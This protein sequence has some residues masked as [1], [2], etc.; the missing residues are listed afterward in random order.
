MSKLRERR[1][2]KDKS[3]SDK[4]KSNKT[5][6]NKTTGD[7]TKRNKIKNRKQKDKNLTLS[8]YVSKFVNFY[9]KNTVVE[10]QDNL[11]HNI[12]QFEYDRIYTTDYV[13]KV[14]YIRQAPKFV[15]PGYIGRI[16]V[17]M[18]A[19]FPTCKTNIIMHTEP[20]VV[21]FMEKKL[22]DKFGH[23]VTT[24][25]ALEKH[26]SELD[27]HGRLKENYR[28]RT[29]DDR[30]S[31]LGGNTAYNDM[32][33][34]NIRDMIASFKKQE[35]NYKN[36]GSSM[37][38]AIFVECLAPDDETMNEYQKELELELETQGYKIRP[39]QEDLKAY[40]SYYGIGTLD[41]TLEKETRYP[42]SVV[43]TARDKAD[44]LLYS[45][46]KIGDCQIYCGIDINEGEAVF[47]NFTS[48]SKA[49][50]IMIVAKSGYGKTY[51][52]LT[53][54][55][56]HRIQGHRI[57]AMD[58][59]GNEW[60][61]F[62]DLYG[63]KIISL[64]TANPYFM[65]TLKISLLGSHKDM[66]IAYLNAITATVKLINILVNATP[67]EDD[68]VDALSNEIIE[69]VYSYH[70]I[71]KDNPSTYKR[72][73]NIDLA[74]D[75][76]RTINKF[77]TLDTLQTKFGDGILNLVYRRLE[78]YFSPFGA[79]RYL[80]SQEV[81]ID[82]IKQADSLIF[83]LGM[84]KGEENT[85]PDKEVLLKMHNMQ[86]I[87]DLYTQYNKEQGIFT[88]KYFEEVQRTLNNPKFM[89]MYNTVVT[90]ERSELVIV[91]LLM[92]TVESL[93]G[94]DNP[95]ALAIKENITTKL[96]GFLEK[97]P[98]EMVMKTFEELQDHR[99]TIERIALDKDYSDCFL[100]SFDT[101][102]RRDV[103]TIKAK[104]PP[105]V[106]QSHYFTTRKTVDD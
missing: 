64:S 49:Q 73:Q 105:H 101:G 63:A 24:L 82:D 32:R 90:G 23:W 96:I 74:D 72:S 62:K 5:T 17:R 80:F 15:S 68:D 6:G 87:S 89:Q 57:C 48:S 39:V 21:N 86:Y 94:S 61:K 28:K 1:N 59:K 16:R 26:V 27:E 29:I 69:A 3:K 25:A 33:M 77:M 85:L 88:V 98:R 102:K 35:E 45:Q 20:Y 36:R 12:M 78:P 19:L 79:K 11:P 30:L 56:F 65:N 53:T 9:T 46:G 47:L 92:N 106:E 22:Q 55:I 51:T 58:Y 67:E 103:A 60:T 18:K 38:T 43:M 31:G 13:K 7:I 2:L 37:K 97:G 34:E 76:W 70:L 14:W 42:P 4:S 44:S 95:D 91:Y 8:Y 100:M 40:Y 50:V 99:A 93:L 54:S 41:K 84:N 10:K 75:I 83:D 104:L 71:E 81:T 52:A 66:K